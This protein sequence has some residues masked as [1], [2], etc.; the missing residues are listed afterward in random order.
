LSSVIKTDNLQRLFHGLLR[1]TRGI[2]PAG[3]VKAIAPTPLRP[4]EIVIDLPVDH[5]AGLYFI[6]RIHTPW[7]LRQDC[8]HQGDAATGPECFIEIE[9]RY[10]PALAGIENRKQLQILYWMDFARR[11]LVVQA[12][13]SHESVKGS[14]NVRSPVRPNPIASSIVSLVRVEKNG[15][16]VR[17]LDCLD[18]TPLIDVKPIYC[19]EP[20]PS[21]ETS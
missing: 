11:D 5:D 1:G 4:G 17:G 7:H 12:P 13:R 18:G 20:E 10:L 14:F 3:D 9:A 6:G 8:P 16:A 15:L 2:T 21:G 19:R